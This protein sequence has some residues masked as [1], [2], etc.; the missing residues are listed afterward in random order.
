MTEVAVA[1]VSLLGIG[2]T[3]WVVY[4]LAR[5][6]KSGKVISSEAADLWRESSGIRESL[7]AELAGV[8]EELHRNR[9]EVRA[10][11]A[12]LRAAEASL[13]EAEARAEKCAER[14]AKFVEWL[15]DRR[16]ARG[17]DGGG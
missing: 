13:R 8:R 16:G 1:L 12:S 15:D 2:L 11:E 7:Q 9:D 3:Q 17:G 10:I 6:S 5:R 14:L 4:A